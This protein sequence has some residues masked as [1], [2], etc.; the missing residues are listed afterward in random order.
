MTNVH[1]FT[2]EQSQVRPQALPLARAETTIAGTHVHPRRSRAG[3]ARPRHKPEW[4]SALPVWT[5]VCT[6]REKQSQPRPCLQPGQ[7]LPLLPLHVC[8]HATEK[9]QRQL[10]SAA[11]TFPPHPT[12]SKA[13][14]PGEKELAQKCS[15]KPSGPS[16]APNQG[17]DCHHTGKLNSIKAPAPDPWAP[18]SHV[19]GL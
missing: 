7:K 4:S 5:C 2:K 16:H 18:E 3:S 14:A 19:I 11:P 1:T 9:E 6:W 13:S 8:M 10:S 12:T 17:R 15:P